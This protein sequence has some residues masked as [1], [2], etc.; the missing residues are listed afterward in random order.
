MIKS[1][2][3][4]NDF[5]IEKLIE[6]INRNKE[7]KLSYKEIDKRFKAEEYDFGRGVIF[8]IY[9]ESIVGKALIILKECP[10]KGIAYVVDLDIN[11]EVENKEVVIIEIIEKV[12]KVAKKYGGKEIF[13][14]VRDEKIIKILNLLNDYKQ[15]SAVK[16]S[17]ED[18]KV[19]CSPLNLIALSMNN[20]KEY[21]KIFNDAFKDV[22]NGAT[23]TEIQVDEYIKKAD[24]NNY[25]Y[26]AT[27]NNEMIGFLQ[28]NIEDNVGEFDLGLTQE[29]RGK[30]YGKQLLETAISF[31]NSK[32][33]RE[34][35]LTVITK[36]TIAYNMYTKRGF[37]GSKLVSQW[38]EIS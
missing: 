34:M 19:R 7:R 5:E 13:L 22:P 26:I 8:K 3:E 21:L 32:E 17:L 4:L 6:F 11:E 9:E 33:V 24:K 27:I 10:V 14:G 20:K 29:A 18:R 37:K 30:G 1:Y 12:K 31:L 35:V 25:Y 38:F 23:V 2:L 16:M 28:F 36:N 15:Y